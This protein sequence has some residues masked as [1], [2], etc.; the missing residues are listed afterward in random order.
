MALNLQMTNWWETETYDVD[1][2]I[3]PQIADPWLWGPHGAALVKVFANGTTQTGWGLQGKNGAPGYMENYENT[4]FASRRALTGYN[5]GQHA[6]AIVMRSA[7]LVCVDIDGKNGGMEHASK[8]GALPATLAEISKSGNGYHLFYETDEEW[9]DDEGFSLIPDHIG[10]VQ[11]VDIRGTGCVYH[12]DTQRWNNRPVAPLPEWLKDKLL[13]KKQR[14]LAHQATLSKITTLDPMEILMLQDEFKDELAKPIK[15]GT[16]N[17]TLFAIGSKM[18]AAGIDDWDKLVHARA[19][20]IG[21]SVNEADK[22]VSNIG[23]YGE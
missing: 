10:I 22:I 14:R 9:D 11:G 19:V 18:K 4:F 1:V 5:K 16:R 6:V 15:A 12:H 23:A 8:L 3:P 7:K 2:V 21:L 20:E 17:T 13:V